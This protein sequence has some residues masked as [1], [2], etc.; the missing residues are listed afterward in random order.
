MKRFST[1]LAIISTVIATSMV[2]IA[3]PAKTETPVPSA[4][5]PKADAKKKDMTK[6]AAKFS[7]ASVKCNEE[8]DKTGAEDKWDIAFQACMKAKGFDISSPA[9]GSTPAIPDSEGNEDD[10]M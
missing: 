6:D 9:P 2:A 1:Y 10:G 5:Q 3:E 4:E 8:A 7:D